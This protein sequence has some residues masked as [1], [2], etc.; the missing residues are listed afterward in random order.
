VV[1]GLVSA[2]KLINPATPLAS[3]CLTHCK[4]FKA[5]GYFDVFLF[6]FCFKGPLSVVVALYGQAAKLGSSRR[7]SNF[8]RNTMFPSMSKY[9]LLIIIHPLFC[10]A[11]IDPA[12]L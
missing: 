11:F 9:Y 10:L 7:L 6:W 2:G 12:Y 3:E 4:F 1:A 5:G 8:L